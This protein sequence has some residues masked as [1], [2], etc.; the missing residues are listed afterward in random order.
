MVKPPVK[1]NERFT[2]KEI[3]TRS[4]TRYIKILNNEARRIDVKTTCTS[5]IIKLI[6]LKSL[7]KDWSNNFKFLLEVRKKIWFT[8]TNKIMNE[9]NM[10]ILTLIS[11][12]SEYM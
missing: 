2:A 10:Y 1:K 5:N 12:S 4:Y 9:M 11:G 7:V 3:N 8:S 6:N